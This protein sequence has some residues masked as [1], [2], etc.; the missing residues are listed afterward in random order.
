MLIIIIIIILKVCNQRLY[1]L[2]KLKHVGLDEQG[3]ATVF[4]DNC[5]MLY[6]V[7]CMPYQLGLGS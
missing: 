4:Q 1:L 3:L 2:D 5:C 6:L 7:Y